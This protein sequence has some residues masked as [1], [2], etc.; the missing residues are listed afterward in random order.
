MFFVTSTV[1]RIQLREYIK[2]YFWH[3]GHTKKYY[4]DYQQNYK[5]LKWGKGK[6]DRTE[7]ELN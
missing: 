7:L 1:E 5:I 6:V 4:E 3:G 2:K